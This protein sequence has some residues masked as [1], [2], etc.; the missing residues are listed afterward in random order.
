MCQ[1]H[2]EQFA[3]GGRELAVE[4]GQNFIRFLTRSPFQAKFQTGPGNE[5]NFHQF[6]HDGHPR[7][8]KDIGEKGGKTESTGLEELLDAFFCEAMP[9]IKALRSRVN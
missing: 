7:T 5:H 8:A 6:S 4:A 3:L 2:L 1:F 9:R